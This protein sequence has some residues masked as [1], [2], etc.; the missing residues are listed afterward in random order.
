MQTLSPAWNLSTAPTAA[1]Y[2]RALPSLVDLAFLLPVFLLFVRLK[3]T[4]TLFAD[5]DTGWHIRTGE[6]ILANRAVPT[7]DLF[8]FTRSS[9]PWFAWEWGADVLFA[10]IHRVG[11]LAALG[12]FSVLLLGVFSV[13]LYTLVRRASGNDA[14]SYFVTALAVCLSSIHWLARPHLFSWVF[15]VVF[16]HLLQRAEQGNTKVLYWTPVLMVVWTN[17]HAGFVTGFILLTCGA[18]GLLLTEPLAAGWSRGS[19]ADGFAKSRDHWQANGLCVAATFINPYGWHLHQHIYRYLTDSELLDRIAEFQ[20]LSFHSGSAPLFEIMLLLACFAALWNLQ[21]G[22]LAPALAVA[23]WA[24]FALVSARHIP[25][26]AIV[27]AAPVARFLQDQLQRLRRVAALSEAAT[28]VSDICEE[29]RSMERPPRLYALTAASV[30]LLAVLFMAGKKPFL[31]QFDSDSFPAQ[32]L[33]FI[34]ASGGNRIFTSDQWG[35]YL[36]YRLYP[37]QKVFF[38]GRS[39]FYG[40]DFVKINQRIA[41]A[42]HDWKELLRSFRIQLVILKPETPLSAVL[43]ITPGSRMLFDDGK[44]IVFQIDRIYQQ[45]SAID[46]GPRSSTQQ[47]LLHNEFPLFCSRRTKEGRLRFIRTLAFSVSTS[48]RKEKSHAYNNIA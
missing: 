41:G 25:L 4:Q 9:Q 35:D 31:P 6:W 48:N 8:S 11:G 46:F 17:S 36:I 7:H 2:H 34:P 12:L 38:D 44:V 29:L 47:K 42:E 24:H 27:A 39:D 18:S 5:G 45:T 3:G 15:A 23:V 19:L 1:W 26:F 21:S 16:L 32:A 10:A 30:V 14:I 20:S 37:T 43:K 40:I 33:P 22:R 28:T 13:L